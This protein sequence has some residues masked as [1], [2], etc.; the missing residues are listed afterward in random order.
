MARQTVS[1]NRNVVGPV[2]RFDRK[3][4]MFKRT[5]WAPTLWEIAEQLWGVAMPL[6][7]EGFI[8]WFAPGLIKADDLL[9]YHKP[10]KPRDYR[11]RP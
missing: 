7:K 4:D 10:V 5:R 1:R 9:G 3:N 2:N 11:A 6:E 8:P